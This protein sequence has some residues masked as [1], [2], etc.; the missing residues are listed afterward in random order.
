M[1][2]DIETQARKLNDADSKIREAARAYLEEGWSLEE[3]VE[4]VEE[5]ADEEGLASE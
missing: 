2:S 5:L 1:T 3:F 4:R